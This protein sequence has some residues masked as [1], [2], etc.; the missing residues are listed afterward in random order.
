LHQVERHVAQDC[1][2]VCAVIVAIFRPVLVH[3]GVENPVKPVFDTPMRTSDLAEAFGRQRCAEQVIGGLGCR[4]ACAVSG[5]DDFSYCR[6]IRSSMTFLDP[7]Y[8][9]ADQAGACLDSTMVAVQ[10][11]MLLASLPPRMFEQQ[12]D[13]GVQCAMIA[14]EGQCV[15]SSLFDD[16]PGDIPPAIERVGGNDRTSKRQELHKFEYCG[17]LVRFIIGSN[18]GEHQALVARPRADH[19]QSGSGTMRIGSEY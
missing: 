10:G 9:G 2:S 5:A 14:L 13:I 18:L 12:A 11:R 6:Q 17:A 3:D 16:L 19:V 15:V 1:E 4:C 8:F 7:C